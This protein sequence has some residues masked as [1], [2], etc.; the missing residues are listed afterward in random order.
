MRCKEGGRYCSVIE[1]KCGTAPFIF[2]RGPASTFLGG[3]W[4][5]P[6]ISVS[7][8]NGYDG[9]IRY[10]GD[11]HRYGGTQ[12]RDHGAWGRTVWLVSLVGGSK[13]TTD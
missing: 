9:D 6:D 10:V 13:R 2:E 5:G 3:E 12:V 8:A 7:S 4:S 1:F 11:D